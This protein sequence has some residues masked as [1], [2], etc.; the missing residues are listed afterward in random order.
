VFDAGAIRGGIEAEDALREQALAAFT[1]SVLNALDEVEG[2][3]V[4]YA[5]EQD[6]LRVLEGGAGS[7]E[8]AVALA[9]AQYGAGLV[10]FEIVLDSQRS[11]YVLQE[12]VAVSERDVTG[13]L[14]RL[15]KALGG[16]WTPGASG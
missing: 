4:A 16:G 12:Q 6:R 3:L 15:Y 13:N 5:Q 9:Q 10:D 8:R 14:I 2:A 7:A 1:S 11:L